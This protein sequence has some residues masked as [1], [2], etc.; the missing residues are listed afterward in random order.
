MFFLSERCVFQAY[1]TE[2]NIF[3][4]YSEALWSDHEINMLLL[5]SAAEKSCI[6]T[7]VILSNIFALKYH[8]IIFGKF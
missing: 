3:F 7:Y 4:K 6:F 5:Q 8:K 1:K 2:I